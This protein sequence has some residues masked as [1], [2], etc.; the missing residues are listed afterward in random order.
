VHI[1]AVRQVIDK[2]RSDRGLPPAVTL[3][4]APSEH[5]DLVITPHP[6][7]TYDILKKNCSHDH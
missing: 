7:S 6:L 5:R 4:L 1:G 3:P 2:R